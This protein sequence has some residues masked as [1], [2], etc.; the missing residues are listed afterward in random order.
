MSLISYSLISLLEMHFGKIRL[1]IINIGIATLL[2]AL[3]LWVLF[4]WLGV[5]TL[6]GETVKV[7]DFSSVSVSD[8]ASYTSDKSLRYKIIDSVFSESIPPGV[9]IQQD[10]EAGSE[11]KDGRVIYLTVTQI[12]PPAEKMPRLV[13]RSVRLAV[14]EL[15]GRGF[16]LGRVRFVPGFSGSVIEQRINGKPVK[17]GDDVP[18]GSVVDLIVGQGEGD[19]EV[20][21]PYLIGLSEED[22]SAKLMQNSLNVGKVEYEKRYKNDPGCK[23]ASQN[24]PYFSGRK[25]PIGHNVSFFLTKDKEK[26]SA[27]QDTTAED[28][29][30]ETEP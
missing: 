12:K 7:P 4:W 21:L 23:V 6:H 14:S 18:K 2:L 30:E 28:S 22:A 29:I 8:L 10:P 26:L 9:V 19:Q 20:Y 5:R 17:E 13:D 1:Y 15:L 25:V 24:P 27:K 11:V 16:K 3:L